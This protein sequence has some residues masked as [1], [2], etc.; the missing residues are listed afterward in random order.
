MSITNSLDT[1]T[2]EIKLNDEI[3]SLLNDQKKIQEETKFNVD[4]LPYQDFISFVNKILKDNG[5]STCITLLILEQL[6]QQYPELGSIKDTIVISTFRTSFTN[7]QGGLNGE[8]NM[9]LDNILFPGNKNRNLIITWGLGTEASTINNS[10]FIEKLREA[11][12][13]F[14]SIHDEFIQFNKDFFDYP[15]RSIDEIL[16]SP[17]YTDTF[18]DLVN[19]THE[20]YPLDEPRILQSSAPNVNGN[21]TALIISGKEV[22]HRRQTI[23]GLEPSWRYVLNVYFNSQDI[24]PPPP[25]PDIQVTSKKRSKRRSKKQSKQRSK[26]GSKRKKHRRNL[27]KTVCKRS[28]Y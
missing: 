12:L 22:Y 16:S 27:K 5:E 28:S 2:I 14:F 23:T 21:I 11:C 24:D 18:K 9:H 20:Q 3:R 25:P 17:V 26:G 10:I 4:Q 13:P 15:E 1:Q 7:D 8:T 19:K 6:F